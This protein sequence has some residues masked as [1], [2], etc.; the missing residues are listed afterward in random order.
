MKNPE[1]ELQVAS[2][3]WDDSARCA[4]LDGI[5]QNQTLLARWLRRLV[6]GDE[7][8]D[9]LSSFFLRHLDEAVGD[10]LCLG[11][12]K[13]SSELQVLSFGAAHRVVATDISA[14]SLEAAREKARSYG[15]DDRVEY[16]EV[17]LNK[18]RFE[19]GRYGM[20]IAQGALHHVDDLSH[21]YDA[22]VETLKPDG[23]L[24]FDEYVGPNRLQ[25]SG[26][27]AILVREFLAALPAE[28]R[29]KDDFTPAGSEEMRRV[30]PSEAVRSADVLPVLLER[31][32][33]VE[34]HDYG[35]CLFGPLF[36]TGC[37][38]PRPDGNLSEATLRFHLSLLWEAERSLI[39][40]GILPSD[41]V[42]GVARPRR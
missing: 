4:E 22:L 6:T 21:L 14:R 19:P 12:G 2:E 23:I 18:A 27:Q 25:W 41:H 35:G 40:S 16:R 26:E 8:V 34:R 33:L 36:G 42:A 32:E 24:L 30:D 5:W 7:E 17:D 1:Q 38:K 9:I 10:V 13:G 20:V 28:M 37:L 31:F 3:F 29:L 15:I 39:E 11:T